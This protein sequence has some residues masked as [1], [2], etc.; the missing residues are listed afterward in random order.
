LW[1]EPYSSEWNAH[2]KDELEDYLHEQVCRGKLDLPTAQR[3]ISTNWI[4]AYQKYFHTDK[5][6]RRN[7]RRMT[8]PPRY[9]NS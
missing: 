9:P 3:E 1:P 7:S 2:V 4:S 8:D 5:P 6:L